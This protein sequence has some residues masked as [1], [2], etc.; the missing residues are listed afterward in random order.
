[1]TFFNQWSGISTL[2]APAT[3]DTT[4][5]K[6]SYLVNLAKK[7]DRAAFQQLLERHYQMIYN[8]AYRFTGHNEDAEDITQ[9]VC[10]GLANKIKSFRGD[11]S[12]K[13]WLYTIIVNS[14]RDTYRKTGS[15]Q[16]KLLG[17]CELETHNRTTSHENNQRVTWL[18]REIAGLD[19]PLRITAFLVLAEDLSHAEVGKILGCSESN[20]SSRMFQV[21][22]LLI[23]RKEISHDE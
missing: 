20:V 16:K 12:F 10:I 15:Q 1:M 19:E 14:C 8:V 3:T 2:F 18:Y 17:Y 5:D 4:G 21:R 7:G 13:T 22:K 11:A 6:D 23:K 9:E